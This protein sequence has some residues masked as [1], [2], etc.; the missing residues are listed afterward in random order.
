MSNRHKITAKIAWQSGITK[1][2]AK[3]IKLESKNPNE[4]RKRK[5]GEQGTGWTNG[6]QVTR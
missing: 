3:E 2:P 1:M 5:K 4:G 6:K